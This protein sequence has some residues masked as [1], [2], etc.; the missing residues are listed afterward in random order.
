MMR[1]GDF[2]HYIPMMQHDPVR[3]KNIVSISVDVVGFCTGTIEFKDPEPAFFH[4]LHRV[5]F[6][7]VPAIV[8]LCMVADIIK[9][10]QQTLILLMLEADQLAAAAEVCHPGQLEYGALGNH[11]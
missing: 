11:V 6:D 9:A 3:L 5:A 7:I 8:K 10:L 2:C 4:F 1:P